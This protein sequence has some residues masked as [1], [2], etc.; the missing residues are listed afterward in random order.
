VCALLA[1]WEGAVHCCGIWDLGLSQF[2][3]P[4]RT[5]DRRN[6]DVAVILLLPMEWL[7]KAEV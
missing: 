4:P 5:E 3:A 2:P 1:V 7:R 6:G